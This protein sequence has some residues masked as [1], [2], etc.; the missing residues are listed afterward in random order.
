MSQ[1]LKSS[2]EHQTRSSVICTSCPEVIVDHIY[3]VQRRRIRPLTETLPDGKVRY[4]QPDIIDPSHAG[5][6]LGP[7]YDPY[8]PTCFAELPTIQELINAHKNGFDKGSK[9]LD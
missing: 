6:I 3:S 1:E 8:C 9:N 2:S 5:V 7:E 4:N